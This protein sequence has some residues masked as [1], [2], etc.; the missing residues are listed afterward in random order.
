MNWRPLRRR[1][2]AV[3]GGAVASGLAGYIRVLGGEDG[4]DDHGHDHD[5]ELGHPESHVEVSMET[6]DDTHHFIPHVVH[7]EVDGT[8]EWVLESGTHDTVAY[9]PDNEEVLPSAAPRRMPEDAE[10]WASELLT[11][12]SETYEHTFEVEGVYDYVCTP[13]EAQGMVGR[14][15]VGWSDHGDEPALES[16]PED[17]PEGVREAFEEYDERTRDVLDAGPDHGH[18]H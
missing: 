5:H 17:L 3:S 1:L 7:V 12:E 4:E 11:E 9:H 18:D 10:P 13:H 6:H 16:Q 14:V 15:I 2:L 8:V